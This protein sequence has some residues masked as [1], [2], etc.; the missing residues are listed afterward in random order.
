MLSAPIA[1]CFGLH[2]NLRIAYVEHI[3]VDSSRWFGSDEGVFMADGWTRFTT[4][5]L[6][7]STPVYLKFHARIRD[8]SGW[9]SQANHIFKCL[10]ITSGFSDY[11]VL[12]EIRMDMFTQAIVEATPAGYLFLCPPNHFRTGP[13]SFALPDC[14]AYW[15]LDFSGLERLTMEEAMHLGFPSLEFKS[16]VIGT[17]W[18]DEIYAGLRQFHAGKGFDPDSQDLAR[19]LGHHLYQLSSD[20][21]LAEAAATTQTSDTDFSATLVTSLHDSEGHIQDEMPPVSRTS[22]LLM[23]LQLGLMLFILVCQACEAI[24]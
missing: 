3:K 8:L 15:S 4:H 22:K 10:Y 5:S 13:A 6:I 17:F 7:S 2:P 19:H 24:F 9:L 12:D 18:E 14:P 20:E 16:K 11:A 21:P 23:N 1:F